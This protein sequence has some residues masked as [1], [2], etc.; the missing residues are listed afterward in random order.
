[1]SSAD[2]QMGRYA[3]VQVAINGLLA[4][5]RSW[6]AG[7]APEREELALLEDG[8]AVSAYE[9]VSIAAE[10]RRSAEKAQQDEARAHEFL[11]RC[12]AL[13]ERYEAEA[14]RNGLLPAIEED[15]RQ[16]AGEAGEVTHP[17]AGY[18][19]DRFEVQPV[20][21]VTVVRERPPG[22][23]PANVVSF[24]DALARAIYRLGRDGD[25]G[26]A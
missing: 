8:L 18:D 7:A 22:P 15:R 6:P 26:A 5:V 17:A 12:E 21:G 9:L 25:G 16:R 4:M 19:R 14:V 2:D 3:D 10:L 1:M 20:A 13:L 11:T 23:T 24:P